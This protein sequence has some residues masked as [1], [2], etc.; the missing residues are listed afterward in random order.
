MVVAVVDVAWGAVLDLAVAARPAGR[1][2]AAARALVRRD[3]R[4]EGGA[5]VPTAVDV[6]GAQ[7]VLDRRATIKVLGEGAFAAEAVAGPVLAGGDGGGER[8]WAVVEGMVAA[9]AEGVCL[10]YTSPSPRDRG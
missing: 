6:V 1:A 3:R 7:V 9:L 10:L 8:V 2:L 5:A 4:P